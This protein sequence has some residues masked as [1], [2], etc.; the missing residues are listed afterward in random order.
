[1]AE[2]KEAAV[3]L[4]A[5]KYLSEKWVFS[6]KLMGVLFVLLCMQLLFIKFDLLNYKDWESHQKRLEVLGRQKTALATGKQHAILLRNSVILMEH[7][8][9]WRFRRT[10]N[11]VP[12]SHDSLSIQTRAIA[13]V[14]L[15]ITFYQIIFEKFRKWKGIGAIRVSKLTKSPLPSPRLISKTILVND[16]V[17]NPAVSLLAMQWGQFLDH[18]LTSTPTFKNGKISHHLSSKITEYTIWY[19]TMSLTSIAM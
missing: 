6:F 2:S 11:L 15:T 9:I 5:R 19:S 4:M 17:P 3:Y 8:T 7:A 13:M 10:G 16:S 18:D 14:S 1:M 12:S